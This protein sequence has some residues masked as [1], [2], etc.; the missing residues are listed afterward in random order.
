MDEIEKLIQKLRR[1]EALH[2]RTG[3]EGERAAA[4]N[5]IEA[6]K[7]RL[8][9]CEVKDPPIEYK[10][11]LA[12]SWS[13][14]LMVALLRRYGIQ[15]YRRPRQRRTTVMARISESFVDETLWPE[16]VELDKILQAYLATVTERVIRDA[17]FEDTADAAEVVAPKQ[18]GSNSDA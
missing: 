9:E 11:T 12:D 10:F 15:P 16:F 3:F 14:Q 13:R 17:I 8:E 1:V 6:I 18:L 4:A 2:A 5:A 7:K